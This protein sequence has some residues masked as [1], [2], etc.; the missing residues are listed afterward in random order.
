MTII[1]QRVRPN[2]WDERT[3]GTAV[4]TTDVKLPGMLEARIL[5]SPHPHA[6]VRSIDTA[7][8]AARSGV[9]AVIT[10][11]DLPDHTYLHLGE[12]FRDRG[13]LARGR[14][15]FVGEE[16]AAVAAHTR[17]AADAALDLIEVDYRPLDGVF[18]P[19]AARL[20]AAARVHDEVAGNLALQTTRAY[21]DPVTARSEADVSV[22]G[23]YVYA[24]AAHV[25][26]EPHSVVARW[27]PT[28][29]HLDLWVS[30]QAPY[31]VRKEVAHMLD[32][33]PE[34]IRTHPVAVGG[35]FGA[36]A[37]AG[38]HEVLAAALAMKA[39]RPVRLV[40]D[41]DEE[42]AAT[43]V[44]HAFRINLTTGARRDGTLT[45]RDCKLTVDNGAYNHAGPSVAIY[46]TML[47]AGPYR[48][49]GCETDVSL[50][51]TNKQPGASFRGYGNPQVTFAT[52]SQIDE[53][54]DELGLDPIELRLH[55]APSSGDVTLTG[56]R[57]GSAR[58]AEC[59]QR[60]RD[61]IGWDAKRARGGRGRGVGLAAA[62][63]VSGA[64]AFEHS[65]LSEAA[66]EVYDDGRAR[67][68]FAGA[69][70]G[71]GQAALLRQI[72]ADELG[73]DFDDVSVTMM[74]SHESP[75]D[76]G[77]WSS[78]GTMW[79]GHAT[80][81]AARGAAEALKSAAA[82]K[83][84]T[85]PSQ[86][87]LIAGEAHCGAD[88][89]PVG[90]LVAL[91]EGAADGCLRVEGSYLTDVDKMD[92]VHGLGH[93]SP[94]YSFCVQAVEVEVDYATGQVRVLDAVTVHD[95]GAALNPAGAEGQAVGAMTM[96]LGAAL[97]EELVYEQGQLV[98]PSLLDYR[99]PRAS[100]LP[101]V[102]AV[103]L[104]GHDPAGP[105]GAKGIGEIG[106][107]PAPAAVANAV[108]HATGVRVREVPIT[109]EKLLRHL[110]P[111]ASTALIARRR[112]LSSAF[113][114]HRM[115][116]DLIRELY[117]RGL[118]RFLH[119]ASTRRTRR[120]G[121]SRPGPARLSVQA[122][123]RP[124]TVHQAL[125]AAVSPAVSTDYIAGGTDLLVTQRQGLRAPVRLIDT[126]SIRELRQLE[127]TPEGDLRIG[128]AVTLEDLRRR[129]SGPGARPGDAMLADLLE[130]LATHQIRELATTGGNLLQEKRCGFYRNG[131]D[132][133][134]R[135]GWTRPCYAVLGD[136]RFQ[137][138]VIGGHRCQ[139][140]TPSDLAT[141]LLA[142][143]AVAHSLP[144]GSK[145]PRRRA[146]NE[147]YA[148][149]GE[150]DLAAGELLTTLE[151]PAAA[152]AR[153][154][155]FEKLR[156]YAGD[157]AVCSAAVSLELD[158]DG[159]TI[160]DAR[161]ALGATAPKPYRAKRSEKRL[162]GASLD[163]SEAL[164]EASWAW[165]TD[166]HPLL[167]NV[168]KVQAACGLLLRALNRIASIASN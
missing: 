96:G 26:L 23:T 150:P 64:N 70:A 97:S 136:H 152:R 17:A 168:W 57:L 99:A 44:R 42:F 156:L 144:S 83:F 58:L 123:E 161:V 145:P 82:A 28:R 94:A 155:A 1:G 50:V 128:A 127:E 108:A 125:E 37:K 118:F 31:F 81:D 157:F 21:G 65:E 9:V 11:D 69:D 117:D 120:R 141:G 48:L 35:G 10:A 119:R 66:V 54:A 95:S 147:L 73:L 25:C 91:A 164:R 40:L 22:S 20:A 138:A 15:R 30:T 62:V 74:D 89:V 7:R 148:G 126:T 18:T 167:G 107:V 61:E 32:L 122:I 24:P 166:T 111:D 103:L 93:F 38:C 5:R 85:D 153:P 47:A 84:S 140:V 75:Q 16:V 100:D 56:W 124:G 29:K 163:D 45:H 33:R 98:N 52:E 67:V 110:T 86:V 8:A 160:A 113:S 68:C 109:P 2:Q 53:L 159:L 105:Y 55:S 146:I 114:F 112:P 60:A 71:T 92:K 12:P 154:A 158:A 41:R 143:D 142:L 88:A 149:P 116:T 51:Y 77:A 133:Y 13:A 46:A 76:L 63:H 78:R 139:A 36:K 102:R 165:A 90:D 72:T 135:G 106:V 79:S 115:W 80:A 134:K 131:F 14:V 43:A 39:E 137:H 49:G 6:E 87:R 121:R 129:V 34:Q 3:S 151:V 162:I 4:Y 104:D 19:Y 27:D 101:H 132:C 130:E 59:L